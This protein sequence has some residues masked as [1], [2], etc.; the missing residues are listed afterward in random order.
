M[1]FRLKD[2]EVL[3][4]TKLKL[5]KTALSVTYLVVPDKDKPFYNGRIIRFS[6]LKKH[7]MAVVFIVF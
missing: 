4:A 2:G 6:E 3:N 7:K 5:R 1:L